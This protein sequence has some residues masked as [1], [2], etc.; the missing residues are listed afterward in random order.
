MSRKQRRPRGKKWKVSFHTVRPYPN[1]ARLRVVAAN[2]AV[3][4]GYR[5]EG[6]LRQDQHH[7][8]FQYS[9]K[10][11]GVFEDAQGRRSLPLGTGFLCRVSDPDVVYFY[12]DTAE[13]PW[14]FMW[15]SFDGPAAE[16]MAMDLLKRHG[17]IHSLPLDHAMIKRFLDCREGESEQD[18]NAA[19]GAEL[20]TQLLLALAAT[21]PIGDT[22]T[23]HA[24][25]AQ[26]TKELVKAH[27]NENI[28]VNKVA[29][30]LGISREHLSRIFRE[31]TGNTLYR[32][33]L[34]SKMLRGCHLLKET[35]LPQRVIAQQLGYES[36]THFSRLFKQVMQM[37]PRA[38]RKEGTIP[39]G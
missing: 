7:L 37:T 5:Q 9:L 29:D 17:A 8:L 24:E 2:L 22:A 28:S 23:G 13:E 21:R 34:R 1:F 12:P 31:Q 32:H 16:A 18:I 14:E 36:S 4:S 30:M 19:E 27:L 25:L 3:D 38:F 35:A 20:V 11:A 33:I 39:D 15:V 6:R 10:G 26:R